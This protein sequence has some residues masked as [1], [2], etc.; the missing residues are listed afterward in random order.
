MRF[1]YF[2]AAMHARADEARR[3]PPQRNSSTGMRQARTISVVVE[4]ITR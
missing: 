4:P 3:R 2:A 1:T